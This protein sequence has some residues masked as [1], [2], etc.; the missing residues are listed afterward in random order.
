MDLT[1]IVLSNWSINNLFLYH[2]HSMVEFVCICGIYL[3]I[4]SK[5]WR[6]Y[7]LLLGIVFIGSSLVNFITTEAFDVFNSNQRYIQAIL[8]MPVFYR[9]FKEHSESTKYVFLETHP[10]FILTAGFL[11]YFIG[12]VILFLFMKE[13]SQAAAVK[14][15]AIHCIFNILLNIIFTFALWR[16]R[17]MSTY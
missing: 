12:T 5:R 9:A 8:L 17:K 15:W 11:V 1:S 4:I 13:L 16:G 10:Y 2:I 3:K 6:K 14:F 7:I